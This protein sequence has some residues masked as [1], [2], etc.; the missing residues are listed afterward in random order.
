MKY[1]V[2]N[3][4]SNFPFWS[5]AK[6]TAEQ[7][8]DEQFELV[9]QVLEE[10]QPEGGWTDTGINDLFWFEPDTILKWAGVYPK[11][12][13][14]TAQNGLVQY[15]AAANSSGVEKVE[16]SQ[17][18]F[19]FEEVDE[20]E[21]GYNIVEDVC[22]FDFE[23]FAEARYFQITSHI[24]DNEIVVR[25]DWSD[26]AEDLKKSFT[27][28][29]I[30]EL[31]SEDGS[32]FEYDYDWG[33]ELKDDPETIDNFV[34]DEDEMW[35][36]YDIPVYAIPRI[37]QLILDPNGALDYYEIPESTAINE[38]NR[39]L[40]LND[41]DV[42]NIN[43]FVNRL[44]NA[45]PEGF[46]I[47]WDAESVGSPYFDPRPAFGKAMDCVKLRVYPKKNNNAND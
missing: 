26:D 10:I 34:Y 7:L 43:T 16:S 42:E 20:S 6:D 11:Y 1:V 45:M 38:Y 8:T 18:H 22:D 13:R 27:K 46:T 19:E 3:S 44:R 29:K 9:E 15:V 24:G 23:D 32:E 30:E 21:A 33:S 4:L 28:C 25:C 40:E 35:D 2:E 41:E 31:H 17:Y 39:Y 36:S 14:L 47:D 37:C 12:Y 5:G